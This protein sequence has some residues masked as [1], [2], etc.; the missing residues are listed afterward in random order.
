MEYI[1][2]FAKGLVDG[3]GTSS[4]GQAFFKLVDNLRNEF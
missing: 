2:R 1:K 4:V 3:F